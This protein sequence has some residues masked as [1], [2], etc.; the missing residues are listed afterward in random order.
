MNRIYLDYAAA[1]PLDPEAYRA[2]EPYFTE[3][4]GNPNSL[5]AEGQAAQAALDRARELV[6]RHLGAPPAGGFREVVFT[7]S[8]TEAN[9][10]VLRGAVVAAR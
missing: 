5:H 8:A 10:L 7:G 6:A 9:N 2:M 4:F 1:V 3:E